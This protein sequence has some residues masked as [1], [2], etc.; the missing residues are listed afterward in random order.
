MWTRAGAERTMQ[1]IRSHNFGFEGHG[2]QACWHQKVV[3]PQRYPTASR[4]VLVVGHPSMVSPR[5]L[6]PRFEEHFH[7]VMDKVIVKLFTA[8]VMIVEY[9]FGSYLNQAAMAFNILRTSFSMTEVASVYM[10]DPCEPVE[11]DQLPYRQ[12]PEHRQTL[13]PILDEAGQYRDTS[14]SPTRLTSII[15]SGGRFHIEILWQDQTILS[16]VDL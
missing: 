15:S 3:L 13:K 8:K 16:P 12:F 1:A 6:L 11:D 2:L 9:R 10:R 5:V 4:V 7:F 14:A